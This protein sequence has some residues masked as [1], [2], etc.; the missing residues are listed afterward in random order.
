VIRQ[1]QLRHRLTHRRQAINDIHRHIPVYSFSS[2]LARLLA[3]P[4][5]AL[6]ASACNRTPHKINVHNNL[7]DHRNLTFAWTANL[8]SSQCLRSQ[9]PLQTEI[10]ISSHSA[11][12]TTCLLLQVLK[13]Q[14]QFITTITFVS[15][16]V[17][18]LTS[19]PEMPVP[20]LPL[21]FT[22]NLMTVILSTINSLSLNYPISS[23]PRTIFFLPDCLQG[24][25]P[26]PF[27]LSYS[28]FVFSFPYFSFLC[29]ALD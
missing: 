19:I 25:M 13:D 23:R 17:S 29:R 27:L 6:F 3:S 5:R 20:L 10:Q 9:Q 15:F 12:L 22:P 24:L 21:S 7:T 14:K 11:V 28:V 2:L 18:G 4:I 16:T 1:W 8:I 26:G